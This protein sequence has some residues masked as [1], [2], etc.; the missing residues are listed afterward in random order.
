MQLVLVIIRFIS[1]ID[2]SR[3]MSKKVSAYV[4]RDKKIVT[5]GLIQREIQRTVKY[6]GGNIMVWRCMGWNGVGHLAEVE[7]RIDPDQYVWD[8]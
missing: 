1:V 2:V 7:G 6:G 3:E 5:E 8:I 4:S